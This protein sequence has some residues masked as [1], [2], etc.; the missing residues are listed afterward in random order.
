MKKAS[1]AM[2]ILSLA[3][4]MAS[5]IEAPERRNFEAKVIEITPSGT[6]T[7]EEL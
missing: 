1:A 6:L 3:S 7:T 5:G 4:V 2:L